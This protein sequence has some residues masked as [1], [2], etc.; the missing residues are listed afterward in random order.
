MERKEKLECKLSLENEL[1]G[2]D[3]IENEDG[4]DLLTLSLVNT[5]NNKTKH[6]LTREVC[7]HLKEKG[8]RNNPTAICQFLDL[9]L[10]LCSFCLN[11]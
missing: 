7:V 9:H 10:P 4:F 6:Y 1:E 5:I 2:D 3:E 11:G 8:K